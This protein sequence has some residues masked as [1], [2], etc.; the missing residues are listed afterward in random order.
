[1]FTEAERDLIDAAEALPLERRRVPPSLK[2]THS[3][4]MMLPKPVVL[5]E[6]N[7]SILKNPKGLTD[8]KLDDQLQELHHYGYVRFLGGRDP[9]KV[10][11]DELLAVEPFVL[12]GPNNPAAATR[13]TVPDV[14]LA[15]ASH[16]AF[17]KLSPTAIRVLAVLYASADRRTLEVRMSREA[18]TEAAGRKRASRK[19]IDSSLAEILTA[20]FVEIVRF[21]GGAGATVRR[22]ACPSF[23]RSNPPR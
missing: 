4:L 18:I 13:A 6:A 19:M 3:L 12:M 9:D 5:T 10:V 23:A 1:M 8:A 11:F 14:M 2:L 17:V 21:G 16:P 22:L 20:G 7:R 15:Q